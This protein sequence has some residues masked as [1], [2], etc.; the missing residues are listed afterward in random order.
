MKN[1]ACNLPDQLAPQGIG[2]RID[3]DNVA[4]NVQFLCLLLKCTEEKGQPIPSGQMRR[5]FLCVR[6]YTLWLT[7]LRTHGGVPNLEGF[8][9]RF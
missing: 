8:D 5:C 3:T 2:S 1:A 6:M 4:Y 9:R 7:G